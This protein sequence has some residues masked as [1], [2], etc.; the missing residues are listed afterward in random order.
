MTA[1]EVV[2]DNEKRAEKAKKGAEKEAVILQAR[3]ADNEWIS[4][5]SPERGPL[6]NSYKSYK[7]HLQ[8]L[9]D[10]DIEEEDAIEQR[11]LVRL[12]RTGGK[13]PPLWSEMPEFAGMLRATQSAARAPSTPLPPLP[14]PAPP[15]SPSPS[16]PPST[17]PPTLGRGKRQ[18]NTE[19]LKEAVSALSP[20]KRRHN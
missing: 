6:I 14:P 15:R 13:A 8:R 2:V 11:E 20:K 12:Q 1:N 19:K 4:I 3:E 18:R 17:A 16:S 9:K 10:G 5:I 7:A